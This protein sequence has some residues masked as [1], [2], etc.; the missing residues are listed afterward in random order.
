MKSISFSVGI[1]AYNEEGNIGRIIES[2]LGQRLDKRFILCEI[3]V[4]SSASTDKTDEIVKE[5]RVRDKRIR[6]LVEKKR[7]GKSSAVNK[8]IRQAKNRY[9]VLASADL[10][11]ERD[12]LLVLLNQLKKRKVGLTAPRI[13]PVNKRIG[14]VGEAVYWQWILHHKINLQFPERPKVGELVA[15]KKIFKQIPPSSPVDEA[16]I[17]PLI[18][19]QGY[20]VKYCPEAVVYNKGPETAQDFLRQR[21]RIYAGHSALRSR[22]GYTVVTYSNFRVLGTLLAN[23]DW[24]P[25]RLLLAL[26]VICLEAMGRGVGWLDYRFK[27]RDHRVWKIAAST[28]K[29]GVRS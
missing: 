28:K 4:V 22:Y 10:L 12:C 8:F 15:F 27:I 5:W 17:E 26:G 16:S 23:L 7:R 3:I 24:R 6:L 25:K 14:L 2:I 19:F 20:G 13:K 11:L 1:C 18:H 9:L 29:L 21:R